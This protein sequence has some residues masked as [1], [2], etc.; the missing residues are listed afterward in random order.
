L[1]AAGHEITV[2]DYVDVTVMP[3][4]NADLLACLDGSVSEVRACLDHVRS[5]P[6]RWCI[7]PFP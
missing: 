7:S 4:C 5:A 2:G 1:I 3:G 6:R